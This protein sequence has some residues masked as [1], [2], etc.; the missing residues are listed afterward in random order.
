MT[1]IEFLNDRY[2]SDGLRLPMMHF[3]PEGSERDICVV[4]IHGMC[5][6]IMGSYFATVWADLLTNHGIGFLFEH[7]RGHSIENNLVSR[8]GE[9]I[10]CGTNFE[11][12]E[13]CVIDLEL[14]VE[15]AKNFGYKRIILLGHSLGCNKSIYY[16]SQKKPEL[17]GLIFASA[18]DMHA[19]HAIAQ[20]DELKAKL[21][22]EAKA[23]IDAG[24]PTKQL[25]T[26]ADG[27]YMSSQTY[28]NW[29]SPGSNLD[30]LP[31]MRNPEKWDQLAEIDIPILTFSGGD[32]EEQYHHMDIIGEKAEKCGDFEYYT[33]PHTDH[34]Y[35]NKEKETGEIILDWIQR[36]F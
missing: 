3:A 35:T 9:Y 24:Q 19:Y 31:I 21:L 15:T 10:R 29:Y 16:Y 30:N 22:A 36:K 5:G 17:I 25:G 23:N 26:M 4:C 2:T 18:P 11:I 12:F 34:S 32:E 6:N 1:K 8:D 27:L 7:N 28:Y 13:E 20:S 33:I 14:A